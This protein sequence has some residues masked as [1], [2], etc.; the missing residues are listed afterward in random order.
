MLATVIS[1]SRGRPE[2]QP[3]RSDSSGSQVVM[4][5]FGLWVGRRR[6]GT[7]KLAG[8]AQLPRTLCMIS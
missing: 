5:T 2:E 7:D 6:Q 1:D 3:E 4:E 8:I